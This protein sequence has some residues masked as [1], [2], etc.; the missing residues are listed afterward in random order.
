LIEVGARTILFDTGG[1]AETLLSNMAALKINPQQ[2]EIVVLSHVHGDHTGGLFS[3]LELNN[4]LTVYL[5]ASFPKDFKE[6]VKTYGASVVEV[7]GPTEIIP[8]VWSTGEM[9]TGIKE[10]ALVVQSPK[11]LLVVTGCAHPG[12]VNMVKRAKEIT[13]DKIH[14]MVGGF[15]MA[16]MSQKQI[17]EVSN[18]S[19][20]LGWRKLPHATA[21]VTSPAN[22]S[23]KLMAT[24]F[25][26]PVSAG[27]S[28]SV[29]VHKEFLG[30][31]IP[32]IQTKKSLLALSSTSPIKLKS[33]KKT[34][35]RESNLVEIRSIVATHVATRGAKVWGLPKRIG[36]STITIC[37]QL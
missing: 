29:S 7:Q 11:G 23:T 28:S 25:T 30:W 5:P 20:S 33:K 32:G 8:G 22:S 6:R 18:P 34:K 21:P 31:L 17:Q 4:A 26:L 1:D 14:L 27:P 15:H 13:G 36:T 10:Q 24:L 3:L 16:G 19:K 2:I 12:V 9:G 35:S 37:I